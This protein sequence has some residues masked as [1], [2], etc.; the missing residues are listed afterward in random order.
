MYTRTILILIITIL[1]INCSR[2]NSKDFDFKNSLNDCPDPELNSRITKNLGDATFDLSENWRTRIPGKYKGLEGEDTVV[3]QNSLKI[4]TFSIYEFQSDGGDLFDYYKSE[5]ALMKEDTSK[6]EIL[7]YGTRSIDNNKSYY[8]VTGDSIGD[9]L[10]N[11]AYFYVDHSNKSY[12][13]QIGVSDASNPIDELCK[14]MWI[15][16]SIKFK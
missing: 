5:L 10:I 14:Y 4:L 9:V 2:Q 11:Q 12:T 13:I 8:V 7:E 15:I 1:I 6:L 3:F 16:E